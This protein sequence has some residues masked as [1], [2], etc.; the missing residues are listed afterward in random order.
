MIIWFEQNRALTDDRGSVRWAYQEARN[1]MPQEAAEG[2][3][4][5]EQV[6]DRLYEG[7][8]GHAYHERLMD[9]LFDNP[10]SKAQRRQG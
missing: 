2:P 3:D 8:P 9:E 4:D 5:N 6:C 7:S 1:F 10:H